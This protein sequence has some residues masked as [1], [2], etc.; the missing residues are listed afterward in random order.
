MLR[1]WTQTYEMKPSF[2]LVGTRKG[3]RIQWA[4]FTIPFYFGWGCETCSFSPV[5]SATQSKAIFIGNLLA[6]CIVPADWPLTCGPLTWLKWWLGEFSKCAR[7][8]LNNTTW[9]GLLS[10]KMFTHGLTASVS[11]ACGIIFGELNE[12]CVVGK[13]VFRQRCIVLTTKIF[14]PLSW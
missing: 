2:F 11:F 14:L 9:E 13:L 3:Y 10:D 12:N 1:T 7:K 4:G 8:P 6:E 5:R